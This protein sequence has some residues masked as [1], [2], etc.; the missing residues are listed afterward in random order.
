MKVHLFF[1]QN[2]PIFQHNPH[3]PLSAQPLHRPT[4]GSCFPNPPHGASDIARFTLRRVPIRHDSYRGKRS[5][6]LG[7]VF[8]APIDKLK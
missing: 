1:M 7:E 2:A 4:H 5:V 8:A 3:A 6:P